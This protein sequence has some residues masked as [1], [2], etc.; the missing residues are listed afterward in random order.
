[1]VFD[2]PLQVVYFPHTPERRST[3]CR[4]EETY[5]R[6]ADGWVGEWENWLGGRLKT[7]RKVT[8]D[9]NLQLTLQHKCNQR[10]TAISWEVTTHVS[11]PNFSIPP[12]APCRLPHSSLSAFAPFSKYSVF[13][14][15]PSYWPQH[16]GAWEHG[17][18]FCVVDVA[19]QEHSKVQQGR[20]WWLVDPDLASLMANPS[21]TS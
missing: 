11:F 21:V 4:T 16:L 7:S 17:H 13:L 3:S 19:R 12:R 6:A 9:T 10:W 14:T 15:L 8:D 2:Y 18:H 20:H 5:I 1:M